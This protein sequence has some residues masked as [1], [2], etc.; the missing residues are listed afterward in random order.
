MSVGIYAACCCV[1][2]RVAACSC[3]WL[4]V[5]ACGCVLLRVVTHVSVHVV[6]LVLS[7]FICGIVWRML[8]VVYAWSS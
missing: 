8:H 6:M 4:R 5:A 3:V 7:V 2:L 1:L